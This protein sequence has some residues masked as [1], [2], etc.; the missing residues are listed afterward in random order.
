M[1]PLDTDVTS[2]LRKVGDGRADPDVTR[3]IAG[4]DAASFYVSALTVMELEIG[5]LR[6]ERR[7]TRQEARLRL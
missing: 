3:W 7:V 4:R 5:L 2:G 1:Y 6:V